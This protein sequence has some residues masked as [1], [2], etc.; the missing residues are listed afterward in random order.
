MP[1]KW[2]FTKEE[3]APNRIT[4]FAFGEDGAKIIMISNQYH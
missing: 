4:I 1:W 3:F 2:L